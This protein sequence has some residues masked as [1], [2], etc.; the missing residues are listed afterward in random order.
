MEASIVKGHQSCSSGDGS[1]NV[2]IR[3]KDGHRAIPTSLPCFLTRLPSPTPPLLFRRRCW[4][5]AASLRAS[6]A[7]CSSSRC[8]GRR[9]RRAAASSRAAWRRCSSSSTAACSRM[10][11]ASRCGRVRGGGCGSAVGDLGVLALLPAA[12][13]G[14]R[15][16]LVQ[17]TGCCCAPCWV[18]PL[19]TVSVSHL[20]FHCTAPPPKAE[21]L[22]NLFRNVMYPPSAGGGLLRLHSTYRHDLKIYS[23]GRC[24][25]GGCDAA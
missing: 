10:R 5:R 6:T 14:Q 19:S 11:G 13:A 25:V 4:S 1:M 15:V 23:S 8:A 22:G 9:R 24:R 7:R 16:Q 18:S 12:V 3:G 20:H 21:T 2:S 17:C